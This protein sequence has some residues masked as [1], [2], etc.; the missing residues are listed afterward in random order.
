MASAG[1]TQLHL[2]GSWYVVWK[3]QEAS[4]ACMTPYCFTIWPCYLT[5]FDIPAAWSDFLPGFWHPQTMFQEDK[6]QG[7]SV[8]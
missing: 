5:G 4:L 2:A 6:L 8:Y 3:T 1:V 7:A